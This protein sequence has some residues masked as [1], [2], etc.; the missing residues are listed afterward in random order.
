MAAPDG[1]PVPLNISDDLAAHGSDAWLDAYN[2]VPSTQAD[3][4]LGLLDPYPRLR[5]FYED[6]P[7]AAVT[8]GLPVAVKEYGPVVVAR[9]R[10]G[11]GQLLTSNS[12]SGLAGTVLVGNSGDLTKQVGLWPL[13]AVALSGPPPAAAA[14]AG[15]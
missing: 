8:Y 2:N 10:Y 15:P 7:Y 13:E 14:P 5:A 11:I 3:T 6:D 12:L 4:T 1:Q 9:F